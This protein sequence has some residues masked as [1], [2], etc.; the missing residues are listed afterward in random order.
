MKSTQTERSQRYI[1]SMLAK[2][3]KRKVV[4]VPA[5]RVEELNK[6]LAAWRSDHN[7]RA[8]KNSPEGAH[9]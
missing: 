5:G 1:D 2:G 4:M 7:N 9:R 6:L 8:V 3:F